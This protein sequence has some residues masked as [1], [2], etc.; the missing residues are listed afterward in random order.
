MPSNWSSTQQRI[1]DAA[2]KV[3]TEKGYTEATMEDIVAAS[4]SSIGAIYHHFGGMDDVFV[5]LAD[6]F[7]VAVANHIDNDDTETPWT[8]GFLQTVLD[9]PDLFRM[10]VG[11]GSPPH[12]STQH[13]LFQFLSWRGL[14]HNDGPLGRVLVAILIEA[15]TFITHS[16]S[17]RDI[18]RV[19]GAAEAWCDAIIKVGYAESP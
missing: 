13:Q 3:F 4:E 10:M 19:R 7:P 12:Y 16:D 11:P 14:T 6:L 1:L 8:R 5:A 9:H 17:D 18:T 15:G 2:L